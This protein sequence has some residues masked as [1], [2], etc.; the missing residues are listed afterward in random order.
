MAVRYVTGNIP[1]VAANGNSGEVSVKS[2]H[3][4]LTRRLTGVFITETTKGN[5]TVVDVANTP[6][7]DLDHAIFSAAQGFIE[8]DATYPA[9][10]QFGF[11]ANATGGAIAAGSN[12][13]FRYEVNA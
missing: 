8:M 7:A 11:T 13:V 1:A 10:I 3:D 6:V 2:L 5:H 4:Q 9:G 12:V